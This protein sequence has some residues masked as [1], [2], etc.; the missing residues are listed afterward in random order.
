MWN[1]D[2]VCRTF[3]VYDTV[4]IVVAVILSASP[5]FET[6]ARIQPMRGLHLLYIVMILLAGGFAGEYLLK[7]HAWRWLALFLPLCVG[8]FYAQRQLFPASAHIEWPGATPM[9]PWVQ[10]FLWVRNNTP[11]DAVFALDPALMKIPGEDSNGFRAIA[12][13][14]M[15][16]DAVKDSG[17]V[18]MF[19]PL[20]EEWQRQVQAQ[21][22]WKKFHVR[23]FSRLHVIYGVTW[24]IIQQSGV[25][26]MSCPYQNQGV[27]VCRLNGS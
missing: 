15:L 4:C 12:Q 25:S 21:R 5:R 10:A 17:A 3:I 27:M 13:R 20:A 2:L 9:N 14:S 19:P 7:S 26:E 11:V 22:G 23:D 24:V 16:A 6:L 8:M 1:V 18:T